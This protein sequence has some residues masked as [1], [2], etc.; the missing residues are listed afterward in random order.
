[1]TLQE[2]INDIIS[3]NNY[4]TFLLIGTD[5]SLFSQIEC[6]KKQ[7]EGHDFLRGNIRKYDVILVD[8]IHTSEQVQKDIIDS[9]RDIKAK[10]VILVHDIK[11][12]DEVMQRVPREQVVW[13][14]DVWRAWHGFKQANPTVKVDY[15]DE[16]YGLGVIYK[17]KGK[18]IPNFISDINFQEYFDNQLWQV[19]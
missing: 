15:I 16:T 12:H 8:G 17:S 6:E 1:M 11:P 14:G 13:T 3:K 2:I 19:K 9:W 7:M 18:L 4:K 10:G 5:A